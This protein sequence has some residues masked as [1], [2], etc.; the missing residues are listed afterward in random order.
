[1][2]LIINNIDYNNIKIKLLNDKYQLRYNINSYDLLGIPIKILYNKIYYKNTSTC[3]IYVN[4]LEC[5]NMLQN[6]EKKCNEYIQ[7]PLLFY[8]YNLKSYYFI[9]KNYNQKK[10]TDS[11][12][13]INISKIKKIKNNYKIYVYIL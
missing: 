1:M 12:L 2:Y 4:D 10:Y 3:V 5:V 6:I 9:C 7:S 13:Y 11:I 8:D